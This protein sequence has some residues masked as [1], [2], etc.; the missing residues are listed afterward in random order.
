MKLLTYIVVGAFAFAS[1]LMA[2]ELPGPVVSVDWLAANQKDVVVLDV[3]NDPDEFTQAPE[4]SVDEKTGEKTLETLGGHIAGARLVDFD[5]VRVSREIEGKKID[6]LLPSAE[7]VQALMQSLGV[8]AGETLVITARSDDP[9]Q[10]D[11]ATRMYWTLKSYG[12]KH[13]AVLDGG[14]A[15]WAGAG[16][17]VSTDPMPEMKAGD[18]KA[19]PLDSTWLAETSQIHPGSDEA[20]IVDARPLPQYLGM[21]FKKPAVAAGGHVAGA[22]NFSPD[23]QALQQGMALKF[24]SPAQ[25]KSVL[26]GVGIQPGD[27][28]VVYC[29]TGH[30]ASGAWFVLSEIMGLPNV[31]LYDG[32]MHEWTT[33][34]HPVVSNFD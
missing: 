22:L 28:T 12:E 15:A 1:P 18:W 32:S 20:M 13:M 14:N 25:Y 30:M 2:A 27:A 17:A 4:Y 26:A 23:I 31:R 6:K 29:N 19:A 21:S 33:L 10:L 34:G 11:L 5:K 24:M 8:N 7:Q 16:Q 3:R 9:G